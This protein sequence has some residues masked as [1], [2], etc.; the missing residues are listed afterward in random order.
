MEQHNKKRIGFIT[1][2]PLARTGFSNNARAIL[3]LLY[4]NP[5][6]EIFLLAQGA[7][8]HDISL[9][10]MPWKTRGA[11]RPGE[12]NE[13]L[14][15]RDPN[16]QKV[17]AYGNLAVQ[18]WIIENKLDCVIHAEDIWSSDTNFYLNSKW[19]PFFKNNFLQWSTADSSPILPLF[20]TWAEACPNVW[21]WAN[22]GVEELHKENKEKFGHVKCVHGV[23]NTDEY[24]PISFFRKKELREKFNI[25]QDT[26]IFFKLGRSQLRK[27]YPHVLEAFSVFQKQNPQYKTKLHFHCSFSEGWPFENLIK[28]YNIDRNDVLVTYF[29]RQCSEY[30]IKPFTGE[31]Q[32]CRFCGRQKTQITAGVNST[33]TNEELSEIYGISDA[34]ISCFTSGGLEL[35]SV[36]SLLCG[37][38]MLCS[39]YSCGEDFTKN[40][41]VFELDG[42][43]TFECG[44]GFIKHVPNT[45]AIVKFM[46]KICELD[47]RKRKEIIDKGRAWALE[48]FNPQKAIEEIEKFIDNCPPITWDYQITTEELK[49][50]NATIPNNDNHKEWV[51]SLYKLILKMEMSDEDTGVNYW[52]QSLDN[53]MSQD[54]VVKYFRQVAA[55]DN[56]RIQQTSNQVSLSDIFNSPKKK[57]LVTCKESLGDNYLI[58]SLLPDLRAQFPAEEYSIYYATSPQYFEVF[59]GNENVDFLIPWAEQFEQ[60][61]LMIGTGGHKG[62]VDHLYIPAVRTQKVLS[63][64]S[65]TE[66]TFNI[67]S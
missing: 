15:Q 59:A 34:S 36:Q 56:Q 42:Q 14:F 35:H 53:K 2:S 4:Q 29:C 46:K 3:P 40:D 45:N 23:I 9:Q 19:W 17:V 33:I 5:N 54:D 41:F 52:V 49:D 31:E 50:V 60:E 67:F 63:Y 12:F 6:Y 18:N 1:S 25:D 7:H 37:L 43:H 55:Q 38:P 32:N 51:K 64:L 57:I 39:N 28:Y 20:K 11:L 65:K 61:L 16:Y 47:Y 8:D 27:L 26:K 66:P 44:T 62:F 58:S 10:K 24:K 22:F 30:E 48:T 13:E 21:F